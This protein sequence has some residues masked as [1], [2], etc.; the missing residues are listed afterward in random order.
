MTRHVFVDPDGTLPRPWTFVLVEAATGVRYS[1]QCG[2]TANTVRDAEGYLVPVAADGDRHRLLTRALRAADP[3]AVRQAVGG[4]RFWTTSA[5]GADEPH[6]LTLDESR[7]AEAEEAWLP[8]RVP[9]GPAVLL[10][11]NSD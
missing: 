6:P 5:D 1:T 10:W 2:G 4:I 3:V 7:L 8:V 11:P 9:G